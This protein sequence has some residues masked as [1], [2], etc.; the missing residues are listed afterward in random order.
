MP[1]YLFRASY[2]PEGVKGVLKEGGTSRMLATE[3][4]VKRVGGTLESYHFSL[5]AQDIC[6]IADLPNNGAA[7]A[8]ASTIGASGAISAFESTALLTPA[9]MDAAVKLSPIYRPPGH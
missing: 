8:V 1:K 2:S 6:I 9:E 3:A 5:G 4:V 7:A